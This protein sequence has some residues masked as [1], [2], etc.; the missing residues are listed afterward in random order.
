MEEQFKKI[1]LLAMETHNSIVMSGVRFAVQNRSAKWFVEEIGPFFYEHRTQI[2]AGDLEHFLKLDFA[3][4]RAHWGFLGPLAD[5]LAGEF[6][7][8]AQAMDKATLQ[9]LARTLLGLYCNY[10]LQTN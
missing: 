5:A 8:M 2:E 10:L 3:K 6:R 1:C 9:R 4:Q 7:A